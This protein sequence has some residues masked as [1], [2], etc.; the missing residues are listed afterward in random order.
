MIT[1]GTEVGDGASTHE[2]GT[3]CEVRTAEH[4]PDGRWMLLGVGVARA[5]CHAVVDARHA[6]PAGRGDPSSHEPTGDEAA[7]QVPRAQ[8]A[9]D[10][11]L[12]TVKRFVV[13]AASVG[14]M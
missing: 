6:V 10:A 13:R 1:D 14:R 9:L 8:H 4:F 5:R 3:I 2:I 12:A 11:Y 7:A